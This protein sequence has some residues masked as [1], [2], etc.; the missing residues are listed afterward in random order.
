MLRR[1]VRQATYSSLPRLSS[2]PT[3]PPPQRRPEN[4]PDIDTTDY[5]DRR[6]SVYVQFGMS[7]ADFPFSDGSGHEFWLVDGI[8]FRNSVCLLTNM[9]L[10][11][12]PENWTDVSVDAIRLLELLKP[13]PRLVIFGTGYELLPLD[14]EIQQWL[15]DRNI[16][17]ETMSSVSVEAVNQTSHLHFQTAR[18]SS[19][20]LYVEFV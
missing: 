14:P 8:A 2:A 10:M 19:D 3:V 9:V 6:I 16:R 5:T 17:Y 15:R 12:K 13:R 1:L 18:C 11:W 4:Y 20:V 7:H